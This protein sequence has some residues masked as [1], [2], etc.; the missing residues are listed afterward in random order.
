[1]YF[2]PFSGAGEIHL[3]RLFEQQEEMFFSLH[4]DQLSAGRTLNQAAE[5]SK[6]GCLGQFME[7]NQQTETANA[8]SRLSHQHHGFPLGRDVV[9]GDRN[10]V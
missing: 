9:P 5:S 2:Q 6:I 7:L 4:T 3:P 8:F 1:M 10:P